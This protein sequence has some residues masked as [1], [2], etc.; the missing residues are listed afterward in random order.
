MF[1][2]TRNGDNRLDMVFSG[3]LDKEGMRACLDQLFS[4]ARGI[5]HG[6]MLIRV[7]DFQ[8]PTAGAL[9]GTVA[10]AATV[11]AGATVRPLCSGLRQGLDQK[12]QR[13]RGSSDSRPAGEIL[14]S[15]TGS[16]GAGLAGFLIRPV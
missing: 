4:Q 7:G 6:R 5:E 16:G 8:M 2:I 11:P 15:R 12:A 1:E 9:G 13:N 14:R 10:P 3:K